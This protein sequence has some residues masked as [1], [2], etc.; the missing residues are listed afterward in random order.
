MA[1]G[2]LAAKAVKSTFRF[3]SSEPWQSSH[4]VGASDSIDNAPI[5]PE[6][7]LKDESVY[8][9]DHLVGTREH[10]GWDRESELLRCLAMYDEFERGRLL[11]GEVGGLGAI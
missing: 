10:S 9:L 4:E 2:P 6:R 3:P 5:K 11:D 1:R 7:S 8:L